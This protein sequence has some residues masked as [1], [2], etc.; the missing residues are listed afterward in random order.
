M[1]PRKVLTFHKV[2]IDQK[3]SVLLCLLISLSPLFILIVLPFP[4]FFILIVCVCGGGGGGGFT[5]TLIFYHKFPHNACSC[6]SLRLLCLLLSL[7]FEVVYLFVCLS[8]SYQLPKVAG[9]GLLSRALSCV[10]G[11]G[12]GCLNGSLDHAHVGA[13]SIVYFTR[14]APFHPLGVWKGG[15]ILLFLCAA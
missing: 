10:V 6:G 3:I 1:G 5:I 9:L 2:D 12:L 15:K 7:L 13:C 8:S 14:L 4:P 11:S